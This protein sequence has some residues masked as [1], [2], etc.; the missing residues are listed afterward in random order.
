LDNQ[1]QQHSNEDLEDKVQELSQQEE[2]EEKKKSRTASSKKNERSD[3]QHSFSAME[4]LND[5]L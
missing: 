5:E 3:L 4:T 2:D 1:G